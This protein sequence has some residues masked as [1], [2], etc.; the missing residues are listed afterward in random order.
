M[1]VSAAIYAG[2]CDCC[3]LVFAAARSRARVL[4]GPIG[5]CRR[6]FDTVLAPCCLIAA[7]F[8]CKSQVS[9]GGAVRRESKI[10]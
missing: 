5:R 10:L 1:E 3:W 9:L 7:S 6:W 2:C 4:R 8:C